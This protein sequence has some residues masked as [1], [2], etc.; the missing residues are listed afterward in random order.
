MLNVKQGNIA[1]LFYSDWV[2]LGIEPMLTI[3]VANAPTTRPSVVSTSA[4]FQELNVFGKLLSW[5]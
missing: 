1:R 2:D 3:S 4:L 5:I